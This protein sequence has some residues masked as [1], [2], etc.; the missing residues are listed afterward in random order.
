MEYKTL[1]TLIDCGAVLNVEIVK[2]IGGW[3]LV[4]RMRD[5]M[6]KKTLTTQRGEYR[7]F[8]TLDA[9]YKLL[10]QTGIKQ[11]YLSW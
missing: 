11:S 5:D 10:A 4:A 1:V 2:S 8:K 6:A 7:T 3:Q 9:A